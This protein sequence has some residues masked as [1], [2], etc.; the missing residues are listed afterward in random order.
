MFFLLLAPIV[1]ALQETWFLPT[2]PYN[3]SL[4]NYSLYR[5]DET[6]GE[7]RHGG[8]ALYICN[9]F[10]HDE[11]T[12][13]TPLQAVACTIRLSGRK[14][15][16]CSIYLP[17]NTDNSTLERNLNHLISQFRNPFLL[18]GDFNAH[19][20]M[21]GRN[22]RASDGRGDIIERFL[23]IHQLV[24]LNK[25]ENTH[26]SLSHNNESAIDLSICSPQL[27]SL[28]EWSVD[29]DIYNSDHYPIKINTTFDAGNDGVPSFVPRWNLKKADWVKFQEFCDIEQDLFQNPEDGINFLTNT[30]LT[31]AAATIP[32]TSSSIR[33]TPVPW[34]SSTVA[35]AI[36][37]RKRAFRC[38]LRHRDDA[39]LLARNRERA[40]CKRVIKEAKRASWQSFLTQLNH[41]TPLS[42]IW[43]LVRSLSGKRSITNLPV[44]HIN[45]T[46]VVDPGEI[47]NTIAENFSRCS[48]SENYR[49]DFVENSRREFHLNPCSFASANTE[50]YNRNFTLQELR[51]AI[52]SAGNTSV[53]PDKLHYAFFRHLPEKTLHFMLST[54]NDLW[55]QHVFPQA[56]R[57]AIVIPLP[58]P[59]KDRGNPDS[60]RPISLISC[61]GKL[62]ERMVG[63]RFNWFVEE[64]NLLSK[65]QSGFR[66]HHSTYDH[67]VR[68]ETDIRKGFKH[69]KQTTAVFLDISRAY[70]M[71][72]KPILISKLHQLG[73]RGHLAMYL[74]A[75]LT[76]ERNFK[77][78]FR[79]AHSHTYSLQN[80]IPQGSCI[81]PKLFNIMINDL[82]DTVPP[83][84]SYSL[85]A[86][87][88]AIWCTDSDSE[89]S[90]PRL[91][92]ALDRIDH[93]SKKNGFIFSPTKS[94]VVTFTKNNRMREASDLHISGHVVPRL[95]SFK[96]LGVVLDSRLTMVKHVEHIKAKCSK[97]LNLFRCI[98]GTEYGA[99]RKTL[100]H[101]YKTLVLPIIEY[102]AVIYAGA[103]DN[104]L[105]KL[106]VIQNSFLRIA[107][108]VMKTSPIPSLQ[109]E[110]VMPP[111]HS[112]RM[113]QSLRYTSKISF[114]PDHS[115]FKSIHVLPSI[116]HTYIGPSEKRSGL[117]IASRIKK[118]S[119]EL[120]YVQPEIRP[121]P[122]L[123][124]PPWMAREKQI[125]YLFDCPKAS[126]S[127][128]EAQQKFLDIRHQLHDFH[129][130]FTDGS[131]VGERTSNAVYSTNHQIA[132]TRL[133]NNTSIYIAEL[134]AVLQALRLVKDHSLKRVVICTDSRSVIQSL[135]IDSPSSA[136]LTNIYNVH[137]ELSVTGTRLRFLWVPGHK[138]IFGNEQA[139][140]FAKEA[141][142]LCTITKIPVEYQSIKRRIR[143]VIT[144]AWQAQWTNT[145]RATQLRR[146]KPQVENWSTA[147]RKN[148]REEKVLSRLRLGH[149]VYTHSYIYSQEARPVCT[150]CNH[151]QTV[152]HI[153]LQCLH[154]RRQRNRIVD[155]CNEEK[156]PLNIATLLGDSHP[157]LLNLLFS[158]LREIKL[159]EK[160]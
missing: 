27:C 120:D 63:K 71:V 93:W 102:G 36:A 34:W 72:H 28:F 59:G 33:R 44:L 68:L 112:R 12:L 78:R 38:Y 89:H 2:D 35:Q 69:K 8:T 157:E 24:L 152:E 86:D 91:Q 30:M 100:L 32:S 55:T 74:V 53:G 10:V 121:L 94:A 64:N 85:F 1:I 147:N 26:F 77:V 111:L 96:F 17:P 160:L 60:Y 132:K 98:A 118:F 65:Y 138:G 108:G 117:T 29:S 123:H 133:E 126:I 153:L 148:R 22:I 90:I 81:S 140:K 124:D 113:E 122:K 105:K 142:S 79:S 107:L 92:Q 57:E 84:I 23:D 58:K 154:Y 119:T 110:A 62:F 75:F 156:L 20:P 19:S 146:I 41:E 21:W 42:K 3:F 145:S 11:I 83:N 131:Q 56:W 88:C 151:P 49:P 80:G 127:Q 139:D 76:G 25:G 13:N 73:L 158:F 125:T 104:T 43:S 7:R 9:D 101:L 6:D 16:V 129:F 130:L 106:D 82:F 149:T 61:F 115:A 46:D 47:L 114:Q 137:Q 97:R 128:Q 18:L 150:S 109:I 141:L 134:H 143:N 4:F 40:R 67:I 144:K 45:G 31:S 14:I 99:D 39:H 66:K 103:S 135:S 54:L 95:D 48:S 116:H 5:Y 136:L 70:D 87:D 159:F 51:D 50:A 155:F 52:S 15:D 37:K